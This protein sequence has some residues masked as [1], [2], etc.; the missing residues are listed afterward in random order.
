M[1]NAHHIHEPTALSIQQII[2]IIV[3]AAEDEGNMDDIFDF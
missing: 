1:K 2:T 3:P